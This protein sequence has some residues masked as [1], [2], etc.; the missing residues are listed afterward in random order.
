MRANAREGTELGR[1]AAPHMERG[2]LVPDELILDMMAERLAAPDAAEGYALDGFPRT[3]A[4]AEALDRR[5]REM[6]RRLDA[7]I[8]LEVTEEE[9]LRRLSGRRVCPECNA[10]YQLET[11]APKQEGICDLCGGRLVQRP[12]ERPEVVRTRLQVYAEETAPLLDYYRGRSL[13]HEV[14]GTIGVDNVLA[15]IGRIVQEAAPETVGKR[16]A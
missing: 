7:A 5:L 2:E 16:E 1:K 10:I 8:Y 15:E 4:Q 14:D 12:D 11:M 13:L 6:H 3:V 9:L